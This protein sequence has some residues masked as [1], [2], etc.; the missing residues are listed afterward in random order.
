MLLSLGGLIAA[1]GAALLITFACMSS[2]RTNFGPNQYLVKILSSIALYGV[3]A[4]AIGLV[5][6]VVGLRRNRRDKSD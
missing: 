1:V 4:F 5:M 2:G 6:I 3:L